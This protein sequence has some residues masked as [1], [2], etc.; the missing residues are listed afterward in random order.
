MDDRLRCKALESKVMT[1]DEA[2]KLIYGKMNIITSGFTMAGYPK[3]VPQAI[4]RRAKAGTPMELTLITGASV[5]PELEES[6]L[7]AGVIKRRFPYQ[8]N[9]K[10][11]KAINE[12]KVE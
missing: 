11:R 6:L 5:G 2:A 7:D 4:A 12:G 10:M 3:D 1:A 8:T 9:N